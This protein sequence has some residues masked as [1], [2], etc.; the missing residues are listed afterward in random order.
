MP[1]LLSIHKSLG[2][3][4]CLPLYNDTSTVTL[5]RVSIDHSCSCSSAQAIRLPFLSKYIPLE[6]PAESKKTDSLP[7]V[8]YSHILLLG[9]SVK[10]ILP[11][12]STAGP[13]VKLNWPDTSTG[14]VPAAIM[15]SPVMLVSLQVRPVL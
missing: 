11:R 8:S 4:R 15:P 2:P 10:K 14:T 13:S 5:P 3:F 1:P 12:L 6:R 9:W 7:S